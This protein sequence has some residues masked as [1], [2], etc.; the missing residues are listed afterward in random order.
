MSDV[1][2]HEPVIK[3]SR[4][5]RIYIIAAI[6][7]VV[8]LIAYGAY[9]LITSGKETTDDAQVSADVVPVSARAAGQ[10]IA[11]HIRENQPVHR[12]DLL[13]ELD[14]QDMLVK[15]AQAESDVETARAQAA[16][17]DSRAAV[18][19]AT[20]QGALEAARGAERNARE[21]VDT[22]SAAINEARGA[23][24]RADANAKKGRLDYERASELGAKGDISRAQVDAAR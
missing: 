23:V 21:N 16:D 2:H 7:I 5:K 24:A 9:A 11:V 18:T 1:P 10:V 19:A 6:A 22:S 15:L 14:P 12:G 3:E 13:V 17:A 8:L 4:A 20:A